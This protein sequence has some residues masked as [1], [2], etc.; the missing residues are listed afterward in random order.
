MASY[1][2]LALLEQPPFG[3]RAIASRATGELIGVCG[4]VPLL[5]PFLRVL[6]GTPSD[7][8]V[9]EVG[10]YWAVAAAHRR[11][12][13]ASEAGAAL[14]RYGFGVLRLRR[15]LATTTF[16]NAASIGVMR[17]LGMRIVRNTAGEP[18]WLQVIGVVDA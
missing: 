16:D 15:V 12:G 6:D 7:R 4:F 10:L 2:Q 18:P 5:G 13:F 9:A 1:E 14:V 11:Q 17:R 3:D 8:H